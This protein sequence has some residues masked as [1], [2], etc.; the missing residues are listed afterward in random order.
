MISVLTGPAGVLDVPGKDNDGDVEA[1]GLD[2][3][4]TESGDE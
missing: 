4:A 3:P 1:L 2:E